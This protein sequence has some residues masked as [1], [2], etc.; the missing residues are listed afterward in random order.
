M[1][2]AIKRFSFI[3]LSAWETVKDI[4]PNAISYGKSKV[5]GYDSPKDSQEMKSYVDSS[6]LEMVLHDKTNAQM[7]IS[8]IES[9]IDKIYNCDHDVALEVVGYFSSKNSEL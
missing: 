2:K 7:I 5:I 9:G 6:G 8:A 1:S 4:F 3:P